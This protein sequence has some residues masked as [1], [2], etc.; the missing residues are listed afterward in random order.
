[1]I[2]K[3]LGNIADLHDYIRIYYESIWMSHHLVCLLRETL[4]KHGL[5]PNHYTVKEDPGLLTLQLPASQLLGLKEWTRIMPGFTLHSKCWWHNKNDVQLVMEA[6][7]YKPNIQEPQASLLMN[8]RLAWATYWVLGSLS[9]RVRPCLK[10][11][12]MTIVVV[13]VVVI[14]NREGE[15]RRRRILAV[16]RSNVFSMGIHTQSQLLGVWERSLVKL[17]ASSVYTARLCLRNQKR[18]PVSVQVYN[19]HRDF[20]VSGDLWVTHFRKETGKSHVWLCHSSAGHPR[21]LKI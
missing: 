11:M 8:L 14:G 10:E 3:Q 7:N 17:E 1:M 2:N 16:T 15:D 18:K 6:N 4:I 12:M 5:S 19:K 20:E 13:V 21:C 9:Y